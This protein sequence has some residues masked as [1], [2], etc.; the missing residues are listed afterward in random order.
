VNGRI[1]W[2]YGFSYMTTPPAELLGGL[3]VDFAVLGDVMRRQR[4]DAAQ[5]ELYR[6]AALLAAFTAMTLANLGHLRYARRWW[7]TAKEAADASGDIQARLWTRGNEV[8]RALYEQRP[9]PAVLDLVA[10][11]EAVSADGKAPPSA[12]PFLLGGKA[13]TLALTGQ[14]AAAEAALH[15]VRDNFERLPAYTTR[16]TASV[17]GF[18]EPNVRFT[19]SAV[20]STLG[21]FARAD[22]AQAAAL[23]LFPAHEPRR[24]VKIKLQRALCLVRAGDVVPGVEHAHAVMTG[25]PREQHDRLIVDLGHKVLGAVPAADR[26]RDGVREFA[27]YLGGHE[28]A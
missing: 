15:E 23:A 21:E 5:R 19:E 10:E 3:Q 28:V 24:P 9:V 2:E 25:L 11:A 22:R 17:F 14:A 7:R 13:Q 4:A 20:Y 16:D 1:A 27:A 8:V 18:S 12:L 6:V 26:G